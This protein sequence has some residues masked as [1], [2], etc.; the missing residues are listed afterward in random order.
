MY[1]APP[2]L[3]PCLSPHAPSPTP[4]MDLARTVDTHAP[5]VLVNT[6][7]MPVAP[8]APIMVS[9]PWLSPCPCSQSSD[10]PPV[11]APLPNTVDT[12][13]P[14]V[15]VNTRL[16]PATPC[17]QLSL[18]LVNLTTGLGASAHTNTGP[19][20][21]RVRTRQATPRADLRVTAAPIT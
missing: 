1:L 10:L 16:T 15:M 21:K 6:R 12:H 8:R 7:L 9:Y 2:W 3:S 11:L 20:M 13:A 5:C 17:A 18:R 4:K 14:C 19:G